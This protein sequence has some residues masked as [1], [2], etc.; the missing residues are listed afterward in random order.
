MQ[1]ASYRWP[2]A[3]V[4]GRLVHGAYGGRAGINEL[5][6]FLRPALVMFFQRR[7]ALDISEDLA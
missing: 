3:D 2:P 7:L 6:A 4:L 5:L 1:D